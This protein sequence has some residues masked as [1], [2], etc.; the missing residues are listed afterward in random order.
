[1]HALLAP[2]ECHV[3]PAVITTFI[4]WSCD[5]KVSFAVASIKSGYHVTEL[6]HNIMHFGDTQLF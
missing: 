3:T 6:E 5:P 2:G 4:I 1:M